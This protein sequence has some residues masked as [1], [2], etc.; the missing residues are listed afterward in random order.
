MKRKLWF[1]IF[2]IFLLLSCSSP[3]K[4]LRKNVYKKFRKK[5]NLT[6]EHLFNATKAIQFINNLC[7]E[8]SYTN[9]VLE[10]LVFLPEILPSLADLAV[11]S[12]TN[13]EK[14]PQEDINTKNDINSLTQEMKKSFKVINEKLDNL[15]IKLTELFKI[16]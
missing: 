13:F 6:K 12:S 10:T 9:I 16:L 2:I 5:F 7:K 8:D 3:K 4:K 15:D 14:L 11:I 1:F